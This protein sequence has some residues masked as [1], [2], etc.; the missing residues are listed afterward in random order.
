[1]AFDKFDGYNLPHPDSSRS[2]TVGLFQSTDP[3]G[4]KY[5]IPRNGGFYKRI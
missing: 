1:M 4:L 2:T 3:K 5:K